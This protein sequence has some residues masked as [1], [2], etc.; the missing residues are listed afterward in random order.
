MFGKA[1]HLLVELK[2]KAY[3]ATR[4]LNMDSKMA[5]EKHM[6]QLSELEEFHNETYEN[7]KYIRKRRNLGTTNTS[8]G[9]SLR[10]VNGSSCLT[11]YSNF[12]QGK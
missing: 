8:Q 9:K 7:K 11:P 1:C 5:D 10:W 3:W 4:Q 2:H 12:S 6:L